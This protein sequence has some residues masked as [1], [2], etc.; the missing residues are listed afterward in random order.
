MPGFASHCEGANVAGKL[1][2]LG[3]GFIS[4]SGSSRLWR[5]SCTGSRTLRLIALISDRRGR[6]RATVARAAAEVRLTRR[7]H[8]GRE[9]TKIAL[10]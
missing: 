5:P 1:T 9:N 3:F 10:Q 7:L 2:L 6:S 4:L 8:P